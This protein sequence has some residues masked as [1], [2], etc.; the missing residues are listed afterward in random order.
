MNALLVRVAV[1]R[2]VEGGSWN[3]PVDS[4]TGEFAFVA[5]P[6]QRPVHPGLEK[7]Y[8]ALAPVLER[9]GVRLP[10]H[11]AGR[12]MH[13][14][15]D[16]EHLTYGDHRERAKQLRAHLGLEDLVVFYA[17]LK[18]IRSAAGLVYA[19]IGLFVVDGFRIAADVPTGDRDMNAHSRRTLAPGAQDLI[20]VGRPGVSGRLRRCLPIGEYRDGA[21]RVRRDLLE[22]WGGLSVKNGYLQRS[23][24]LPRLLDPPRFLDWLRTQE[25]SLMPANN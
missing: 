14:D 25:P 17:G 8:A 23:A 21:Y 11:L 1:D 7:P 15:P 12:P 9:F 5:I 20:V 18:D 16:F 24:R 4:V 2:S 13:L 6:E 10:A 3:G 22:L 19:I